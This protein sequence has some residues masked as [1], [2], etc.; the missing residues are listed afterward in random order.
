MLRLQCSIIVE[1]A[2]RMHA[3]IVHC[4]TRSDQ[5]D[6][7][8]PFKKE[9][10]FTALHNYVTNKGQLTRPSALLTTSPERVLEAILFNGMNV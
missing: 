5:K 7:I 8:C 6:D 4:R 1:D 10:L 3:Y 9:K 2:Y